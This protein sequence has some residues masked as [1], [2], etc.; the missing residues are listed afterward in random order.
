MLGYHR[1]GC[2]KN[3]RGGDTVL[4]KYQTFPIPLSTSR[5]SIQEVEN[6]KQ[7]PAPVIEAK[8]LR[9]FSED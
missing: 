3:G 5:I 2:S 4:I 7:S 6:H 1:S 9:G 8:I